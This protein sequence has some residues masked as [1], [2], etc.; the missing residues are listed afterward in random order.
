MRFKT[1]TTPAPQQHFRVYR[2]WAETY[3]VDVIA[4]NSSE[5]IALADK[6]DSDAWRFHSEGWRD[7]RADR[8]PY[9]QFEPPTLPAINRTAPAKTPK[10]RETALFA[11]SPLQS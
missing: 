2:H 4:R 9:D 5:A 1:P 6:I 11:I 10:Y 8:L 3:T 7:E